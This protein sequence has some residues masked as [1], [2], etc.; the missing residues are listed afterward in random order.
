MIRFME[1]FTIMEGICGPFYRAE[2]CDAV[3][4]KLT[5]PKML[6][7]NKNINKKRSKFA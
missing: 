2:K 6:I 7:T 3:A 4:N 1:G 5:A